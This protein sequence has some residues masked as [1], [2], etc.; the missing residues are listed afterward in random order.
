MRGE[1]GKDGEGPGGLC[2]AHHGRGAR[3]DFSRGRFLDTEEPAPKALARMVPQATC[4]FLSHAL[5]RSLSSS[6]HWLPGF[7]FF[8]EVGKATEIFKWDMTHHLLNIKK[9]NKTNP[10]PSKA[11]IFH[12]VVENGIGEAKPIRKISDH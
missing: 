10:S 6:L 5:F 9:E 4:R 1:R 11:T 2:P 3:L 12:S 8:L 7:G